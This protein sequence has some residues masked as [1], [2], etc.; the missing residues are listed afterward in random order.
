MTERSPLTDVIVVG[1]GIVGAAVVW[2]LAQDGVRVHWIVGGGTAGSASL[3]AGAMLAVHSEV[4][5]HQACEVRDLEVGTRRLGRGLWDV[6]LPAIEDAAG[7]EVELNP[8]V[9]LIGR[10]PQD[11][12]NLEAIRASAAA[13]GDRCEPVAVDDVP[14][15]APDRGWEPAEALH[16]PDEASLDGGRLLE[17]LAVANASRPTVTVVRERASTID[18]TGAVR[19][20]SGALLRAS[21]VVLAAGVESAS[22]LDGAGLRPLAPPLYAGRGVSLLVRAS[23]PSPGCIRTPNRSFACGLHLVPR[24]DSLTYLGA[25][26]RFSTQ[27]AQGVGANLAELGDLISSGVRELDARLRR[28]E[29]VQ[30]FVGHRPV[31]LDRLPLVGRTAEPA[32]LLATATWRNGFVMAPVVAD[33]IAEELAEPGATGKHPFAASRAIEA[34]PLDAPAVLRAAEGIADTLLG[35]A[36]MAPGRNDDL[37]ALLHGALSDAVERSDGD[38]ALA[39]LLDR[40]PLEETLPLVFDLLARRRR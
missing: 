9:H 26:N 11:A 36:T 30:T 29:V 15:L 14:G 38:R 2:R 27:P 21:A 28:A 20:A 25:T 17:A 34:P 39:R 22:L 16:L 12:P 24:A 40:A 1:A 8:G 37:V 10:G 13:S 18:A 7:L 3:A 33:L 5:A 19:T 4:S 32:I 6:W 35:G 23:E 31:T